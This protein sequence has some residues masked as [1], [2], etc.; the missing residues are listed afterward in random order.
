MGG[1]VTPHRTPPPPSAQLLKMVSE[2]HW[3]DPLVQLQT[4]AR[5]SHFAY[6]A[7]DHEVTM[8][9][10]QKVIQMGVKYLKMSSP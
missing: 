8:A 6:T 2:C 3:T 10:S 5:L 1:G 7:H 9:C 4:L